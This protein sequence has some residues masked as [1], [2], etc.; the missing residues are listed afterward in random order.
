MDGI[1]SYIKV[2]DEKLI[3]KEKEIRVSHNV[4]PRRQ[5]IYHVIDLVDSTA[6]AFYTVSLVAV[7]RT[8]LRREFDK[9]PICPYAAGTRVP[10]SSAYLISVLTAIRAAQLSAP[11]SHKK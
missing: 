8:P 9:P 3:G 4:M 1:K 11:S 10:S 7:A 2:I 6:Q 5:M